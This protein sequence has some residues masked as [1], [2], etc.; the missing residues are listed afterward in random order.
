M[1]R[2]ATT[3]RHTTQPVAA[4]LTEPTVG[5]SSAAHSGTEA[6]RGLN[7]LGENFNLCVHNGSARH[8]WHIC[9]R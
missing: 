9:L 8:L 3:S 1:D 7:A 2:R 4:L 6:A 5:S